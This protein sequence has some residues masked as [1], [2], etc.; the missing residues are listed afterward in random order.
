M[1]LIKSIKFIFLIIFI[2]SSFFLNINVK[3]DF[4]CNDPYFRQNRNT[5]RASYFDNLSSSDPR[6]YVAAPTK[7][8]E[9]VPYISTPDEFLGNKVV[10]AQNRNQGILYEGCFNFNNRDYTFLARANDMRVFVN[11]EPLFGQ[12]PNVT[13]VTWNNSYTRPQRVTKT[14]PK[15]LSKIQVYYRQSGDKLMQELIW[16][17]NFTNVGG[18][19]CFSKNNGKTMRVSFFNNYYNF[20]I[21][22]NQQ[23]PDLML[24]NQLCTNDYYNGTNSILVGKTFDNSDDYSMGSFF[25]G[26]NNDNFSTT[27]EARI[28][29]ERGTY[30]FFARGDDYLD[31]NIRQGSSSGAQLGN[32][33]V[34]W[35][36]LGMSI[37][38]S[39]CAQIEITTKR[40]NIYIRLDQRD[41]FGKAWAELLWE[42]I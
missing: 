10:P 5:F 21:A 24:N 28:N 9:R 26:I 19:N 16:N 25:P 40:Q 14:M 13:Q 37:R 2:F 29:L 15:G 36:S 41:N 17:K 7:V 31:V 27:L 38:D 39:D 18:P 4:N 23:F 12:D 33:N 34:D 32:C 42:K 20:G 35:R 3:A 6:G 1:K 22:G 30:N 8:E 11:D